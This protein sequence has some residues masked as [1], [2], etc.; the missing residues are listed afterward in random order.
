VGRHDDRGRILATLGWA[1][2]ARVRY[3]TP[4][5]EAAIPMPGE[6]DKPFATLDSAYEFVTLLREAV[7]DAYESIAD[8]IVRAQE[9]K[10]S[11]RRLDA[12]R[13]VDYKLNSLRQNVLGMLVLLNDLR[14]LR[15]LLLG[16]RKG[17]VDVE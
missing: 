11:E 2:Q 15:R 4:R 14:S 13:L 1:R 8:D 9:I 16:E 5:F 12:L 6:R 17:S 10:G 3:A 7:D